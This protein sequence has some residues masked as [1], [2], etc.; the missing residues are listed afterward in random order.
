MPRQLMA[1]IHR[2]D[3]GCVA[4]GPELDGASQGDSIEAARASLR[5]ALELFPE[6][7]SPEE[8]RPRMREE[9]CVT[10]V[11]VAVG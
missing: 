10:Q 7:A 11:E 6:A 2:G 4:L 8:I 9:V 5:E 1:I 3:G